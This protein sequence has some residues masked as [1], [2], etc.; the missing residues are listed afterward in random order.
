MS[1]IAV[2]LLVMLAAGDPAAGA[3]KYFTITVVDQQTGRGVPLVELRTVNNVRY[4]TDSSGTVA[5]CEPGLM[6]RTVFFYVR[7]DGY[8]FPKDG[9]GF[10]GKA[11]KTTPGGSVKLKIKRIN[12]AQRLYRVTGEG[13]YR[14]SVLVGRKPPIRHPLLDGQVLGSDSVLNAVFR[15]K[16]YWFW[17]DTNR[18]GY[19]LGNFHT[20][21]ATSPLPGRGGLDPDRG[22]D[23]DYFVDDK[24]FAKETARMPGEGPTWISGLVV[25]KEPDSRERLFASYVKV[26]GFLQVYR[27]G[28]VEFDP[29][30]N[31]FQKVT[32][33]PM[34]APAYPEGHPF[35]HTAGGV[36]YVYF[37]NPFPLVRVRADAKHLADLASYEAYTCLKDGSRPENPRVDRAA[38]GTPRYAWRK[39]IRPLGQKEETRLIRAGQLKRQEARLQLADVRTGKPVLA[40][41]D[42]LRRVGGHVAAGRGL[43]RRGR[44]ARG[45]L[46]P[47]EEDRHPREVQLLQPQAGPDV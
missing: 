30:A 2:S 4:F 47:G 12:I 1:T 35:H 27:R 39:N 7:S 31:R 43:V 6:D 36:K 13:I 33:F 15:G 25:L 40:L 19:P 26:R 22:V 20:P 41:G 46:A 21:G 16:I 5:F 38:D 18:P 14:D 28:L 34:D 10:R 11:V 9:F 3:Q 32:E 8:E 23:L 17:G 45:A 29:A 37:A 44:P 42:D 24:G